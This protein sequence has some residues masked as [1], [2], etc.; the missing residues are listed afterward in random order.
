LAISQTQAAI[1]G[2]ARRLCGFVFC[3]PFAQNPCTLLRDM[4][5]MAA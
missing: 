4:L 1:S 5:Y 3:T 2:F